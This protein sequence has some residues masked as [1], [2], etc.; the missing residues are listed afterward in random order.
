MTADSNR[1]SRSA[2]RATTV[3]IALVCVGALTALGWSWYQWGSPPLGPTAA[4]LLLSALSWGVG[5]PAVSSGIYLSFSSVIL[6]TAAVIVGPVGAALLGSTTAALQRERLPGRARVFNTAMSGLIGV[7][8]GTTY[9][10]AGGLS[11]VSRVRG[12]GDVLLVLVVPL[13]VAD[14]AQVATNALFVAGVTRVSQGVPVGLQVRRLAQSTGPAY[15]AQGLVALLLVLLWM[16]A[17]LGWASVFLIVA[18][19]LGGRWALLQYAAEQRAQDRSLDALVG[20]IEV[21]AP[22]LAG[23]SARVAELSA[24]MAEAVG[25]TPRQVLD[26][27][28]GGMLH[29]LGLV[30]LPPHIVRAAQSG[31]HEVAQPYA[32]RSRELLAG[33][34]FLSG[35]VSAI[36]RRDLSVRRRAAVQLGSEIVRAADTFDLLTNVGVDV[37]DAETLAVPLRTNSELQLT[38]GEA[39]VRMRQ[40]ST[41]PSAQVAEAL[42]RALQRPLDRQP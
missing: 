21:K 17:G 8:A 35:V 7:I 5:T 3:F 10:A 36:G 4:L 9:L 14:L 28:R 13:L 33:L 32:R 2:D 38:E 31:D 37:H 42:E 23:H 1:R 41:P 39:L 27:R 6:L 29:D 15:L 25:M 19:L 30:T 20:A 40:G 22:Y 26:V 34:S 24:A 18:P 12:V 11:D 16:P